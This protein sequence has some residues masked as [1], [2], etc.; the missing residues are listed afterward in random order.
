VRYFTRSFPF[1]HSVTAISRR[2]TS[3]DSSVPAAE[4][5]RRSMHSTLANWQR[6]VAPREILF[7]SPGIKHQY[8]TRIS[9]ARC[10]YENDLLFLSPIGVV[11][12]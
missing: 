8:A 9:L 12:P 2:S 10:A 11:E 6:K 7:Q 4:K 1:L 3:S 5:R